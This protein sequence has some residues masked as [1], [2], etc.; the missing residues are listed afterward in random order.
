VV[1]DVVS[2][3]EVTTELC[4]KSRFPEWRLGSF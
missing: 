2:V 4:W 1:L 3:L